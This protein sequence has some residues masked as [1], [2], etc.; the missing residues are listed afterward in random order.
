MLEVNPGANPG[1]HLAF[2]L[3]VCCRGLLC[4]GFVLFAVVI[5]G[6]V[7][8]LRGVKIFLLVPLNPFALAPLTIL[9]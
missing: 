6:L 9:S 1:L 3:S 7:I 5:F 4:F 2:L 8:F